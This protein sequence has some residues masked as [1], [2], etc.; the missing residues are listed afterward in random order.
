MVADGKFREDLY[1]R[2]AVLVIEI[3]PLRERRDDIPILMQYFADTF[4]HKTGRPNK[5][6]E[7][8]AIEIFER[9]PYPGN[10]RELANYI[11]RIVILSQVTTITTHEIELYLPQLA[12]AEHSGPL[13]L[14]SEQFERDYIQKAIARSDG[15][16]TKA[17]ELLGLERSHLYKKMKSLGMDE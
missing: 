9:Y 13:K 5:K 7:R 10:I 16:M 3:P 17:A 6:F 15:N 8:S 4:C 12:Q 2:L 14:A 11:E 1:Y